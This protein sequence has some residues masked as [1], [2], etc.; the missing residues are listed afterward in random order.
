KAATHQAR[1]DKRKTALD[2]VEEAM[3]ALRNQV[4]RHRLA[5][6]QQHLAIRKNL[7]TSF[8]WSL[9]DRQHLRQYLQE[10]GWAVIL[11]SLEADVEIARDCQEGDAVLTTDCDFLAYA[12]VTTV[13]RLVTRTKLLVYNIP[14][15]LK[16][17]GYT[18]IQLTA[19]CVVSRNDYDSN[20][21]RLGTTTN[22]KMI[23]AITGA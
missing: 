12:P 9:E 6:K 15:L 4:E 8:R 5:T 10:Q 22:Y 17:I 16:A 3:L 21:Y 1:E 19:L 23:K 18:R 7:G 14:E 11:S 2:S 13:W 20:V